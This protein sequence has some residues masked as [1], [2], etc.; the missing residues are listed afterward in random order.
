M[1][2]CKYKDRGSLLLGNKPSTTGQ[3]CQ[4]WTWYRHLAV[5]WNR[6]LKPWNEWYQPEGIC[7]TKSR[8]RVKLQSLNILRVDRRRT[9]N[10]EEKGGCGAG[11]EQGEKTLADEKWSFKC[12]IIYVVKCSRE[13]HFLSLPSCTNTWQSGTKMLPSNWPEV[14]PTLLWPG[15]GSSLLFP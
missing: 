2:L 13:F 9:A 6:N 15:L 14:T 10:Q 1:L 11:E 12:G 4:M 5:F 3:L 8:V 7:D